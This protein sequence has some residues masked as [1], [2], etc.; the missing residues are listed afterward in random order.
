MGDSCSD[1]GPGSSD[2]SIQ[3]IIKNT[4]AEHL[5]FDSE[6]A[7]QPPKQHRGKG[8]GGRGESPAQLDVAELTNHIIMKV[9]PEIVDTVGTVATAV[10]KA[11][12]AVVQRLTEFLQRLFNRISSCVLL[13]SMHIM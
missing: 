9:L 11:V 10:D 12:N 4:L 3:D 13:R 1:P 7:S 8:K 5:C 6:A 2:I